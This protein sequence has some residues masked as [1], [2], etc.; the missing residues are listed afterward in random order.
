MLFGIVIAEVIGDIQ[1][2]RI[3]VIFDEISVQID[4]RKDMEKKP[5]SSTLYLW[6]SFLTL[7]SS[8]ILVST[9]N[10]SSLLLG[11]AIGTTL[12]YVQSE[13]TCIIST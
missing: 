2:K 7:G 3:D 13:I 4:A 11:L 1:R 9:G 10:Q 12:L 8:R 5:I 6:T